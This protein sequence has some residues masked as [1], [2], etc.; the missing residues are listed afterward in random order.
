MPTAK[1]AAPN[2]PTTQ[3]DPIVRR[4]RPNRLRHLTLLG[5]GVIASLAIL[6]PA[7]AFTAPTVD[8]GARP[9]CTGWNSTTQPPDYIRVLRN[10]SGRVDRVPF[11]KYVL[12][13]LGKEWPAICPRP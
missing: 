9:D 11:K 6:V 8:A 10:Q 4:T 7:Q 1:S 12:T 2:Q 5:I 13:V 3:S